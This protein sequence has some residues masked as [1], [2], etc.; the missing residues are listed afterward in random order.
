M[1][2]RRHYDGRFKTRVVIE[3]IRGEKT[4]NQIAGQYEV[5]PNLVTK[6]KKEV[7]DRLPEVLSESRR[8]S[9]SASDDLTPG[10]YQQIGQLTM[11]VAYLKKK[12][13]QFP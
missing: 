13:Q 8:R 11:E 1:K 7:L 4:A 6:W 5:H 10:L 9:G 2:P 3:A 12:L